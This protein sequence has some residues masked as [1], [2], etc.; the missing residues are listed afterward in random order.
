MKLKNLFIALMS[1]WVLTSCAGSK[2]N[3]TLRSGSITQENF[4]TQIPFEYRKGLIILKVTIQ[5]KEYDFVLDTGATN[6]IS[7]EL[8]NELGLEKIGK[9]EIGDIHNET[10]ELD[11]VKINNIQIG[12]INFKETI[13][14]ILDIKNNELAFLNIDG[15]IGANL[16]RFAIWDFDFD[17]QLITI[18]DK[19]EM[20]NIPTNATESKLFI[21]TGSKAS[22]ITK[23]N[24][25]RVLNN[26]IDL[27]NS[28]TAFL[29]YK[30]FK[31]Q[32]KSKKIHEYIKGSGVSSIGA[33]GK[34]KVR[35]RYEAKVDEITIGN[36]VIKD[37]IVRIE[38]GS[39][40]LGI[41]FFKN[42]RLI[43][44]WKDKNLK[45]I[46]KGKTLN[47]KLSDFG[48][49]PNVENNK[50]FVGFLYDSTAASTALQLGDQILQMN[51]INFTHVSD[52][53]YKM[54]FTNGYIKGDE[55]KMTILRD[56]KKLDFEFKK[57]Q[58]L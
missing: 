47:T 28:S 36:H 43:L 15:L 58:L 26:L 54:Y 50:L 52:E 57:A 6:V 13:G 55:V 20:L 44:N 10:R 48:F 16:M 35:N 39:S 53:D 25:D 45:M 19:E 40:N 1:I 7:K 27:G 23:V 33:F 2:I 14:T 5:D 12:G 56:G 8:A 46:Q 32:K 9:Q 34:G 3:K 51:A 30:T 18:T 41:A 31:K 49:Y 38:N 22:I 37:K 24:G 11:Y 21:G 29:S 17:N 42:Y 4:K